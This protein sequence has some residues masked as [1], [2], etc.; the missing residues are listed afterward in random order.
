[1]TQHANDAAVAEDLSNIVTLEHVNIRVPDQLLATCDFVSGLLLGATYEARARVA[2]WA[3]DEPAVEKYGRLTAAEYRHGRGSPLGAR[4]ERLM[5]E[6]RRAVS[7]ALPKLAHFELTRV[8]S[9]RESPTAVVTQLLRGAETTTQRAERVLTVLCRTRASS[10]GHLYLCEA[11]GPALIA[12]S[13][14]ILPSTALQAYVQRH[15]ARELS[16]GDAET[17]ILTD[18]TGQPSTIP[19]LFTDEKGR[20]HRPIFLSTVVNGVPRYAAIAVVV[21]GSEEGRPA[22]FA[23]ASALAAHLIEAGDTPGVA[24]V[25]SCA[26]D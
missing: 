13:G 10:E 9:N 16:S 17:A 22:D 11:D 15:L 6:A 8:G 14:A 19:P 4:Y 12:S 26:L 21:G 3:G 25:D 24:A 7:L 2:I 18:P 23:L 1:M 5:D 20:T